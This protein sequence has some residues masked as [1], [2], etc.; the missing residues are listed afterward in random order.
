MGGEKTLA[1]DS[2]L[3]RGSSAPLLPWVVY[4]AARFGVPW[5]SDNSGTL[6]MVEIYTPQRFF[7]PGEEAAT[8]FTDPAAW[9]HALPGR[10][11]VVLLLLLLTFVFL[12]RS[13]CRRCC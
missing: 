5:I 11:H 9:L 6:T 12:P 2:V 8:L 7:V 1:W 3:W 10:F 4:S 13:C